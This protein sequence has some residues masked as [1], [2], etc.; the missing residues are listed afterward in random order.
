MDTLFGIASVTKGFTALTIA[1]LIESGELSFQSRWQDLVPD[2]LP[3]VD[4]GVTIEH[5]LGHRSG[6]GDYVDEETIESADDYLM[7]IPIH[8]L[9]EPSDY[10]PAIEPLPQ[11]TPPD[12]AFVYNNSGYVMLSVAAER[13][14]GESFY[15]LVQDRVFA[16][17]SMTRTS[18]HRSDDLPTNAAVGYLEDGRSNVLHLPVRGA[19]D[20]GAYSCAEDVANFWSALLAGEIVSSE[21][22][23]KLVTVRSVAGESAY[24]LG[25]WLAD[26]GRTVMLVG[27]DAGVSMRSA[28][29]RVSGSSYV[30]MA[31]T[32]SG[33]WPMVKHL[34]QWLGA[35]S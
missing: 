29:D 1:S 32:S 33:A 12:R 8:R 26:G 4:D 6:V 35:E 15:S 19:G 5:L 24:G 34:H 10:L 25:F 17:A 7:E 22:V 18:F 21:M 31:N 13:A 14:A 11:V 27:M 30:V 2:A 28:F 16:P 23:E 3:L 9:T 20:G